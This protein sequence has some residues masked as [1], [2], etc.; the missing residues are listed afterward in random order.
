MPTKKKTTAS[1][2][3]TVAETKRP[4]TKKAP[5]KKTVAKP[6]QK[7]GTVHGGTLNVRKAADINS[8]KVGQL[9]S[10]TKIT[11]LEDLGEWLKIDTGYVMSKW[12]QK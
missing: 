3:T 10:G 7:I 12:V 6:I 1:A 8:D 4:A 5:V 2:T 11:I 9:A